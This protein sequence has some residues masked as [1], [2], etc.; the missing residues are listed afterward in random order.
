MGLVNLQS[1]KNSLH[2][3]SK[4]ED[5]SYYIRRGDS[6]P[7]GVPVSSLPDAEV[8]LGL[9]VGGWELG[10]TVQLSSSCCAD[11]SPLRTGVPNLF[12]VPHPTENL[13][14]GIDLLPRN[15]MFA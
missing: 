6:L 8:G 11:R 1:N 2:L 13:L 3:K 12:W 5:L 9:A 7:F 14:E 10:L 4:Y 15:S